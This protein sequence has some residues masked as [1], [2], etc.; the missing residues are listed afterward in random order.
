M[1]LKL[2]IAL[3]IVGL[4]GLRFADTRWGARMLGISRRALRIVHVTVLLLT[5]MLSVIF[6]QWVLLAVV[7]LLLVLYGVDVLRERAARSARR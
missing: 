2:V 5:G 1:I 7:A 4:V 6:E 3:V